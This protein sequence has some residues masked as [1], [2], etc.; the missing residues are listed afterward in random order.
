MEE[1]SLKAEI[2]TH[3]FGLPITNTFITSIIAS[4][5]LAFLAWFFSRNIS[6]YPS[7]F[8]LVVEDLTHG[9]RNYV[10]EVL[11]DKKLADKVF[12]L[13]LSLF[14]FI[15]FLNL[16]KF[17]PGTESITYKG[18]QLLRPVHSDLNMTIALAIVS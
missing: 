16:F 11:G 5:V 12:P 10:E 13:I 17:L 8:Q 15:L 7:R 6:L 18:V 14:I 3:I 4:I 1:V 2:I 9:V